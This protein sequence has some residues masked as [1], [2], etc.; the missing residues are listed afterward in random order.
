MSKLTAEQ[1]VYFN[2][3][4]SA[5]RQQTAIN[6]IKN[7]YENATKAYIDSCKKLKRKPSKNPETSASEILSYP[8]VK[9]FISSVKLVA[10]K[11]TRIDAAYVLK[12]SNELLNRCMAK[13]EDFHPSGAGKALDLIGKHVDVQAFNDKATVDTVVTVKSFNDMYDE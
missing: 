3:I 5:L 6:Y 7:G 13:G 12:M 11:D 9:D 4:N 10:A 2:L 8:N 1:E